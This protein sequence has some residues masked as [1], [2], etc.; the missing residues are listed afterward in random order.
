M[1]CA[2]DGTPV[3]HVTRGD[4]SMRMRLR[5]AATIGI[6]GALMAGTITPAAAET[7]PRP[8]A[9]TTGAPALGAGEPPGVPLD[10]GPAGLALAST[11]MA[12]VD[13]GLPGVGSAGSSADGA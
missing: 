12:P 10:A 9:L 1:C 4:H 13:D 7:T 3:T 11:F 2:P 8:G 5:T 6:V